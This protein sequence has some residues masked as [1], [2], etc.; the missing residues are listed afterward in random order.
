MSQN[1]VSSRQSVL[2]LMLFIA[3]LFFIFGF[4]TWLNGALIPFLQI[5]CDLTEWQ[6]LLV[7][8][9][10]Y[11]A[12]V[13][14]ALPMSR[15]LEK[16]G[17]QKG[18]VLGLLLVAIGLSV[19]VPAALS[20]TFAVFLLAQFTVGCGLTLLQTA[21]N[22]YIVRLGPQ[23]S[24]AARIAFMGIL[25][26]SAG[27]LA[28]LMFTHWV[29]SDF[30]EVNQV[31][32]AA[33]DATA[34]AVRIEEMA[35]NV[36]PPYLGM[37]LAMVIL[38]G[39]FSRVK[40]PEIVESATN[41]SSNGDSGSVWQFPQL[42]LGAIALFCYVGVEV[43]AGDTIGLYGSS[44]GLS[45]VT[46]FTSYTMATMVLG[47]VCGLIFI[48][49]LLSQSQALSVS[50]LLGVL[51]ALWLQV[52]SDSDTALAEILWGWSGVPVLPDSITL[53]ALLG[54][55]NAMCWPTIWPLA[56][57]GLGRFTA[58]G[59]AILIMGI[60]GGALMPL[61]YGGLAD[62]LSAKQAYIVLLPCYV[63]IA[64]YALTGHKWRQWKMA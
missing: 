58:Q 30:G 18:M 4:I 33:L 43:I 46:T 34:R 26:K 44:L 49:R 27:V 41:Q 42:V 11:I 31:S 51:F 28:P 32:M 60:A 52:S 57:S 59:A 7:A 13:V 6:A 36:I 50:A 17:Y 9:C 47:Y 16:T 55:A 15:V 1:A 61:L 25:N 38:A 35:A 48:P 5:I 22:P 62:W 8:F 23:E 39:A 19:F 10:F 3:M 63:M 2:L 14:M 24:A 37:A 29:L 64:W 40:L 45:R 20:Q 56:L 54:F 21:S 53:I 12:Y